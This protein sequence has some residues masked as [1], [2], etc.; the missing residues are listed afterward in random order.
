MSPQTAKV[1]VLVAGG[2]M[3]AAIGV[4]HSQ[5][6]DPFRFAWAAGAITLFLSLLADVAPEVAGPFAALVLMA[7]YWKNRGVL[8]A[9][10]PL[11]ERGK[12]FG[13]NLAPATSG[14][15]G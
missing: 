11:G 14:G 10:T 12:A 9:A 8:G 1:M 6:D 3:F 13:S 15:S 7:V 4:R 2:L 5:I